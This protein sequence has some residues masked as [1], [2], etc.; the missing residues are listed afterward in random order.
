MIILS[1]LITILMMIIIKRVNIGIKVKKIISIYLLIEMIII[2]FSMFDPVGLNTVSDKVYVL[3]IINVIIFVGTLILRAN[4]NVKC[5]K[6]NIEE[7]SIN[8]KILKSRIILVGQIML[9]TILAFYSYR[10]NL[11]ASSLEDAAQIR[12]AKFTLLFS[13]YKENI[14]FNYIIVFLYKVMAIITS[15]LIANKNIKNP[16]TIMGIINVILYSTIGYGRMDLYEFLLF[17]LFSYIICNRKSIKM[18]NK[19]KK[20][21]LKFV[22]I[23]V[24]IFCIGLLATAVRLG[25]DITDLNEI[26]NRGIKEQVEQI[27]IYFTGGFRALDI[28]LKNGFNGIE[29]YTLGRATLAGIDEM[30]EIFFIMLGKEY[31]SFNS[32]IGELTQTSIIVGKNI[33]FNAFYTSLMNYISD[34]GYGGVIIYPI[35]YGNF[36]F[37]CIKNEIRSQTLI[38]KIL[39]IYVLMNTISTIYRWN[40]QFGQNIFI[41]IIL[42]VLNFWVKNKWKIDNVNQNNKLGDYKC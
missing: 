17:I 29:K 24:F 18:K 32:L 36:V 40:Y 25:I 16:I 23:I 15:I 30:I 6:N 10:F 19:T 31:I 27:A 35:L 14:F 39:V 7:K 20:D 9:L 13:S 22:V 8:E 2:T 12:I 4:I 1:I 41:L 38:S 11:I 33:E 34:F 26:Y 5:Q 37:Y 21:I 3:W 42:L 28:F